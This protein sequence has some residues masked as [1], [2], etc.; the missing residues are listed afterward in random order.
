MVV[1]MRH[2]RAH[3]A[4]RRSHHALEGARLSKCVKCS[5]LHLRHQVCTNCGTYRGK[6]VLKVVKTIAKTEKRLAAKGKAAK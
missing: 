1:R 3:T 2:T 6:S 5:E 4:N